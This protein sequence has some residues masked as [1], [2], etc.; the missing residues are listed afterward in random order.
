MRLKHVVSNP[1]HL[2]ANQTY[3]EHGRDHNHARNGSGNQSYAGNLAYSYSAVIGCIETDSKGNR[4]YLLSSNSWSSTTTG[5]W[6]AC[7]RAIPLGSKTFR[8][9]FIGGSSI[10]NRGGTLDHVKNAQYLADV[11]T[12]EVVRLSRARVYTSRDSLANM[13]ETLRDYVATFR[14]KGVKIPDVDIDGNLAEVAQR[15]RAERAKES[16]RIADAKRRE[17]R[18]TLKGWIAGTVVYGGSLRSLPE[19]YLRIARDGE[20]VQTSHGAEVPLHHVIRAM[21]LVLQY[22]K[23]GRAFTPDR[24]IRLGY[25][26]LQGIDSKG[27]V[28]IGC[29][30]FEKSEVLRFADVLRAHGEHQTR[31]RECARLVMSH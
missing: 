6:Y 19:A 11:V 18:D 23:T 28:T 17:V 30:R 27:T 2:W 12:R 24:D 8:V 20:T 4:V 29:H 21:P 7:S 22:V 25:Y 31:F 15:F 14:V 1:Y 5:H 26:S 16:K 3:A 10:W 13:L 9:P